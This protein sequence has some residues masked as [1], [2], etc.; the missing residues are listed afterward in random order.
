MLRERLRREDQ[1]PLS[2]ILA[3]LNTQIRASLKCDC[4]QQHLNLETNARGQAKVTL[5]FF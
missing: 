4:E 1:N 5:L 2:P 3:R